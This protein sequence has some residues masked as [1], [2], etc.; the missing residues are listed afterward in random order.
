[1]V[2]TDYIKSKAIEIKNWVIE[3]RRDFH[4]H[5]ELG[6]E[7]YRTRDKVIEY[8]NEM[9]I[10]N[11][12]VAKTGVMGI[13]RGK[14]KG[15]TVALRA[16]IDALP[17]EDKKEVPYKSKVKGKMHACGHDAHTAILL[18]ASRMLKDLEDEIKGNIKLFF[19]PAE[20]TIGGALPMI[21]EGVLEDPYVD[22]VFG[23]HVDNSIEA[24]QIGIRYGQMKAASDEIKVNIYGKNSH[25]AYPQDGV[26]AIAVAGQVLNALQM[27]VSRNVDP[28]TS[29]VLT[30]GT[31]KGGCAGNIIA[32]KV[33]MEGIVR[34]LKAES[35]TLVIDKIRDIVEQIPK[36]LGGRGEMIRQESYPPLIND[37]YMVDIIKSNGLELLEEDSVYEIPYPSFG[38]EDF[39]YF[40][41]N[42]PSAFFQLGSGNREKGIIYGGHTPYF[43]IDEECLIIGVLLQVKNALEFLNTM[44]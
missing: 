21:E 35:R 31:I 16:D 24:G 7:E 13:I 41:A 19:Q 6:F 34:T 5:P 9:S 15:K 20:E 27:V 22:G 38:V 1:M 17:M 29:A 4:Q 44:E 10:E 39:S 33:E 28:R 2:K 30:I 12:I 42:R 40:A 37:D 23:L 3:I 26:D 14:R 32:D 18:G 11:K 43:D 36:S 25:G 8:L